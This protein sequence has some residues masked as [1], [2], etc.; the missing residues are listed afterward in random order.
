M[1]ERRAAPSRE[2][3]LSEAATGR[4]HVF[5]AHFFKKLTEE[6]GGGGGGGQKRRRPGD[7]HAVVARWTKGINLFA[8]K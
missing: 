7:A 2:V 6:A 1:Q 5:T 8:K 3:E 4:A